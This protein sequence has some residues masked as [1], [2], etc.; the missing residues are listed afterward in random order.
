MHA[1]H[2]E[3]R[4][5]VAS[6]YITTHA[7]KFEENL[8]TAFHAELRPC[9]ASPNITTHT[10][11]TPTIS[12]EG[13]AGPDKNAIPPA[14]RAFDT[15]DLRR[16]LRATNPKRCLTCI[17][18]TIS[19]EVCPR[20][21][22]NAIS[23]AFHA[24][25]RT[26]SAEGCA[27]Q[28]QNAVSPACRAFATHDLGRG[29]RRTEQKR[30]PTPAFKPKTQSH[31]HVTPSTRAISAEGCAGQNKNAITPAC[32]AFDT[33]DLRRGLR[34]TNPKRNLTCI[35][36]LR[37]ARSPQ[38]VAPDRTKTQSH[39][40]FMPSTR[41]ISAEGCARQI[42]NAVSPAFRVFDTHDLCRRLRRTEQ[43]RNLACI[44]RLPR[45]RAPQ[46]VARDKSK[47]QAHLHFAPST[48]AISARGFTFVMLRWHHPRLKRELKEERED[49][50][51]D[52]KM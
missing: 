20:Q 17:S 11:S 41:T 9:V 12:A 36:R 7:E 3:L 29:L 37:H 25:T 14:S 45:A 1:S 46:R 15:R 19:A 51:A 26:I 28:I 16:G 43:K 42:Q 32:H 10:P 47:T 50:C 21:I 31:L 35:S 30:N 18:R 4:P 6:P 22:E 40:H 8:C 23:P 13:C 34:A 24:L 48:R 44:S 33:H 52:V 27:R 2:A 38:R 49:R 39:L 5:P